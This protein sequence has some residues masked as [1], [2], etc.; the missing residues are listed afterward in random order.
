MKTIEYSVVINKPITEVFRYLE[1]LNN[2]PNWEP[3]VVSVEILNGKYEEPGS[4]IQITNQALGKKMETIAEVIEYKENEHVICRAQKPFFHEV[5]NLYE[6]LNGQTK[7]TRKATAD[8]DRQ[9]GVTKLASSLIVKKLEKS[10]QKTVLTA[11][12]VLEKN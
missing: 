6:D 3:G 7:F 2:R 4:T 12:E 8:F 11:K 9:G 5:S 10:F 1:D